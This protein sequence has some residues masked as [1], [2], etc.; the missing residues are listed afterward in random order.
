MENLQK[1]SPSVESDI[2]SAPQSLGLSLHANRSSPHLSTNGVSS[3]SGKTGPPVIQGTVEVLTALR[4]DLQNSGRTD[5]ELWKSCEARWLQLFSVVEQ[6]CQEQIVAQQEQFHRQI[7]RIQEEIRK[8]VKLQLSHA[9]RPS[10][11]SSSFPS[12]Q[13]TRDTASIIHILPRLPCGQQLSEQW[14]RHLLHPGHEHP[15]G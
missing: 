1:T 15:Q 9:S 13:G 8:L 12:V 6:H 5:S 11:S 10:C 3:F 2:K 14:L 7:R 4:Q